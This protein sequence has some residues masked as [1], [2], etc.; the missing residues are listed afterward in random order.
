MPRNGRIVLEGA[1]YHIY[2][3]G[4]NKDYI[5]ENSKHKK[6]DFELLAYVI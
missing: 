6:F 2:Q 3:K 4:N 5:F 1:I